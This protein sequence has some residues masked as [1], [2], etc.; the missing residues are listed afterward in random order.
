VRPLVALV[1]GVLTLWEQAWGH[2]RRRAG[3]AGHA[4]SDGATGPLDG[5]AATVVLLSWQR[6]ANVRTILDAYTRYRRVAE[7]VVWNNNPD[8]TFTYDH[9]KVRVVNSAE[10]GLSTRWAAALL[11]S[12]ACVVV[13]DDD[14]IADEDTID[15]LIEWCRQ[16]PDRVYTLH[17]RNPTPDNEYA[18]QVDRVREPTE[19]VMHLTRLACLDRRHVPHYFLAL[20]EL[21]LRIDPA[22]GGGEDIVMSFALA[23]ATGK[24]PLVVPGSYRDLLA[25]SGIANRYGSQRP[26]RTL[27]MRRCQAWL[28]ESTAARRAPRTDR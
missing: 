17:G 9:A 3:L 18:E 2:R 27:I 5:P 15:R 14:L 19:A 4:R 13:A 10:L 23:R 28:E 24:R 8:L 22:S 26:R 16:D 1:N 25:P 7:I 12:H 21:G 6:P 20:E 11:A